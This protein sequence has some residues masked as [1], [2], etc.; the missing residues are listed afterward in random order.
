MS[1]KWLKTRY[2]SVFLTL[3]HRVWLLETFQACV[4]GRRGFS[5]RCCVQHMWY[6]G[7]ELCYT[8]KDAKHECMASVFLRDKKTVY[9]MS[10]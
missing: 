4:Q 2:L 1:A 9:E 10:F 3:N 5:F 8:K 6:E 7:K